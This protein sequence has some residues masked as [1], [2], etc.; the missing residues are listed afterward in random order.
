MEKELFN[1]LH[2]TDIGKSLV[3]YLKKLQAEAT[4]VRN[5]GPNDTKESAMMVAS[6]IQTK[7]IDKIQLQHDH[8]QK[9][10]NDFE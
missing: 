2:K 4:D 10:V 9:Q 1:A 3:E 7:L 5:W 8:K 6:L